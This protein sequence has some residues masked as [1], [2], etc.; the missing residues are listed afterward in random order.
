MFLFFL[1]VFK[2][3]DVHRNGHWVSSY[4]IKKII[5]IPCLKKMHLTVGKNYKKILL[6]IMKLFKTVSG[7]S[8]AQK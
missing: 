1:L 5:K 4:T 2:I 7:S 3:H 8:Y 6:L